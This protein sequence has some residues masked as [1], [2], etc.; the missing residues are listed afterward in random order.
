MAV[1]LL[2]HNM[3]ARRQ[4]FGILPANDSKQQ[5]FSLLGQLVK[6]VTRSIIVSE[7]TKSLHKHYR[8]FRERMTEEMGLQMFP[9]NR[10]WR[11]RRDFQRQ[12][13]PQSSSSRWNPS[14]FNKHYITK[15]ANVLNSSFPRHIVE[16]NSPVW[17]TSTAKRINSNIQSTGTKLN[18]CRKNT[19]SSVISNLIL[20]AY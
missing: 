3:E 1:S 17:L 14:C 19:A 6:L 18:L 5:I 10:Y 15:Q 9:E 12:S 20:T 16:T 7:M 11:R 8:R 13:V 4:V 2:P